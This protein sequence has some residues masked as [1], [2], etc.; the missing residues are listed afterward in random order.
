MRKPGGT[1]KQ[2]GNE[3][4]DKTHG[5]R[6]ETRRARCHLAG[7]DSGE[8]AIDFLPRR[9]H[10]LIA[11]PITPPRL[12]PR[13]VAPGL[14]FRPGSPCVCSFIVLSLRSVHLVIPSSRL[15]LLSFLSS[16][17]RSLPHS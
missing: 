15:I 10:Q 7:I 12:P 9:S 13:S 11:T 16:S 2:A 8:V 3:T 14:S 5:T 4:K 1:S 6:R 17:R